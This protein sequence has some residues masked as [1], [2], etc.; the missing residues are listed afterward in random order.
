MRKFIFL[1]FLS[2]IAIPAYA[3][4]ED[5]TVKT[6][7]IAVVD[8]QQL[9]R[10]SNAAKSIQEQG[11]SL[12]RKYQKKIEALEKELKESGG[13]IAQAQK[14]KDEEKF[15]EKRKEFQ[16]TLIENRKEYSELN[17]KLDM[18]VTKALNELKDKIVE[19]VDDMTDDNGY[20]LVITRADVVIVSKD[21]DITAA[22]MKRLN[23][24]LSTVKVRE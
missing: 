9:M 2:F 5:T 17:Q 21:I 20:D 12:S 6:L 22:V 11:K 23:K 13:E 3:A 1:C 18:A 15:I 10:D 14:E 16:Q 8:V 24:E 4:D 19:I 7:N